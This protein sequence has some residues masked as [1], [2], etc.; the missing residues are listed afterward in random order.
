MINNIKKMLIIFCTIF[1]CLGI[2]VQATSLNT[3]VWQDTKE[4][5]KIRKDWYEAQKYCVDLILQGHDDWRLPSI[6]ELQSLVDL[7]RYRP[8]IKDTIHNISVL[9]YYWSST[10]L[11]NNSKKAWYV[12]YKYGESYYGDKKDKYAVKCVRTP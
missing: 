6:K 7:T 4:T 8:A 12:F 10:P 5:M 11:V 3:I 1:V 9:T 2:N